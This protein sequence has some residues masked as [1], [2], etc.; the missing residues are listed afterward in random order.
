MRLSWKEI[1]RVLQITKKPGL[2]ESKTIIKATVLG[3]AII[4]IIGFV[5]SIVSKLL[6]L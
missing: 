2:D 1:K 3:I 5:I 4:G 6:V